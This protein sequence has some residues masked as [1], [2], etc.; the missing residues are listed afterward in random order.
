MEE[1]QARPSSKKGAKKPKKGKENG[2]LKFLQDSRT[3]T[4]LGLF[5]I[6]VSAFLTLSF[7]SY[8]ID[9]FT[10]QSQ[11]RDMW[12]NIFD[13]EATV[14]NWMGKIGAAVAHR[15]IYNWFGISAFLFPFLFLLVGFKILF[16]KG[17][18]PL[19][20]SITH[21]LFFLYLLPLTM[22]YFFSENSLLSGALG[23]HLDRWTTSLIGSAGTAMLLL[24]MNVIYLAVVFNLSVDSIKALFSK[25]ETSEG[26]KILDEEGFQAVAD[27]TIKTDDLDLSTRLEPDSPIE[28]APG[29]TVELETIPVE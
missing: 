19:R 12:K 28:T 23:F 7:I 10:D 9:G 11:L 5:F 21:S 16:R 4:V 24:F 27:V 6:I 25:K 1:K 2:I 29:S 14:N 26:E 20:K 22:G 13:P 3:R 17:L 8:M 18:L 15:F